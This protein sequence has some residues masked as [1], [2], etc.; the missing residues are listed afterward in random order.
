MTAG[1]KDDT[2]FEMTTVSAVSLNNNNTNKQK[3]NK[4]EEEQQQ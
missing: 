2:V 1:W 3:K 4:E